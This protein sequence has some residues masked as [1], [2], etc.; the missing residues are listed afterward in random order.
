MT[1]IVLSRVTPALRG[2]LSRWMLEVHPGV[3]VG[4]VSARVREKLWAMVSAGRRLG[5][6]TLAWRTVSEQVF[7]LRT[8]GEAPREPVDFVGL[9]LLRRL[10]AHEKEQPPVP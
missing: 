2:R 5:S 1:L 7:S 10:V 8:A 3:F 6:C 9:T 4:T